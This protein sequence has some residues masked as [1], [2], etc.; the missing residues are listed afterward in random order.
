MIQ[1]VYDQYLQCWFAELRNLPKVAT[2]VQLKKSIFESEKYLTCVTNTEKICIV[3]TEM[4]CTSHEHLR[5]EI[6]EH[7]PGATYIPEM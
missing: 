1:T 5:R 7:R 6:Q 2:Y 3:K 4:F